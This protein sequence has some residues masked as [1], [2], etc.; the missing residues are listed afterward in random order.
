MRIGHKL[1]DSRRIIRRIE[2]ILKTRM[3]G[4]SQQETAD[5]LEVDRS[6]VSRLE[7]LGQVRTGGKTALVGFPIKNKSELEEIA[8]REGV[9][10]VLLFT[11]K[12]RRAYATGTSGADLVNEIMQL[13]A[14][15][16]KYD[17]VIFIGSDMR[18]DLIESMIGRE[19]VIALDIG[20]SPIKRDVW[21]DPNEI[22]RILQSLKQ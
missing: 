7:T 8:K 15:L 22:T 2:E 9:D 1:I 14:D 17:A 13:A 18:I 12:E 10:Y 3:S 11:D 19:T 16:K 20:R 4:K 21:V 6:F 5:L